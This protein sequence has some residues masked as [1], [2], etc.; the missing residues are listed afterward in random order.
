[1]FLVNLVVCHAQVQ[2]LAHNVIQP[3]IS[4]IILALHNVQVVFFLRMVFAKHAQLI[5][6]FAAAQTFVQL[7][8]MD[9]M[10]HQELA[11]LVLLTVHFVLLA[12]LVHHV[13]ME[14]S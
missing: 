10:L 1:M 7:V 5:A 4:I 14:H 3:L 2:L 11:N 13:L 9:I 8:T 12:Q 6:Q